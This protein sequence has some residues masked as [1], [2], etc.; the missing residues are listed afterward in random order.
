MFYFILLLFPNSLPLFLDTCIYLI[1]L[2]SKFSNKRAASNDVPEFFQTALVISLW[3]QLWNFTSYG[4]IHTKE[5]SKQYKT[6]VYWC[7]IGS[8]ILKNW[9][10]IY[11]HINGYIPLINIQRLY[12]CYLNKSSKVKIDDSVILVKKKNFSIS[13][14]IMYL[15]YQINLHVE[16][17]KM[18]YT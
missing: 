15:Q 12:H 14:K 3:N 11:Q 4:K 8:I 1:G 9:L 16:T 6:G 10:N 2:S 13:H 5:M 7:A 17:S 18:K